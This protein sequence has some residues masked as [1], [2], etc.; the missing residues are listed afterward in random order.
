MNHV[1]E[2]TNLQ[3]SYN[4]VHAVKDI[5]FYVEEGKLF[6]FLGPNGAGKSTTIN[7]ICTFLRPD[8]GNVI[9]NGFTLGKDD[10]QIRKCI[11]VVF[12]DGVL[13]DLLTVEENLRLRA[14]FYGLKGKACTAAVKIRHAGCRYRVSGKAPVW[15]VFQ[16]VSAGAAT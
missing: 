14:G 3:K 1:I 4:N 13:D 9:V 7:I 10:A 6:A 5:S 2:V 15:T 11:G 12:Q 16:A 8:G